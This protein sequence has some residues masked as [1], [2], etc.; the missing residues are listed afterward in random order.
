MANN[1]KTAKAAPTAAPKMIPASE[2]DAQLK[3]LMSKANAQIQQ[4]AMQAQNLEN[5]LR[6]KTIDNLF[7][8]LEY[9]HNFETAFVEK[10]AGVITEYLTKVALE[11]PAEKEAAAKEAA[12]KEAAETKEEPKGE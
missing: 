7:K 6:D 8:V 10:C 3:A 1:E 2:A 5:M 12:A 9:S 11:S 4:L